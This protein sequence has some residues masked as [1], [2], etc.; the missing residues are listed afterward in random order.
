MK[1]TEWLSE[2]VDMLTSETVNPLEHA[3]LLAGLATVSPAKEAQFRKLPLFSDLNPSTP[4]QRRIL[5]KRKRMKIKAKDLSIAYQSHLSGINN[6]QARQ[7]SYYTPEEMADDLAMETL[8]VPVDKALKQPDPR[9][10]LLELTICDPACGSGHFLLAAMRFI[11]EKA[12]CHGIA[13]MKED[14]AKCLFGIDIDPTAVLLCRLQLWIASR[15][16]PGENIVCDDAL[17]RSEEAWSRQDRGLGFDAILSNPPYIDSERMKRETPH[18]RNEIAKEWSSARGNWDLYVP[19]VELGLKRTKSG[20]RAGFLTPIKLFGADY[21]ATIQS[22]LL[23]HRIATAKI[24]ETLEAF[25]NATVAVMTSVIDK[26]SQGPCHFF[27]RIDSKNVKCGEW[28]IEE[29]KRLPKGHWSLPF[30]ESAKSIE[31]LQGIRLGDLAEIRDGATTGEAYRIRER[32]R[33]RKPKNDD[34][35]IINTGL[36]D[37]HR[38]LWGKRPIRYLGF[39]GLRPV[40]SA[41]DLHE[42][43]PKRLLQANR[44]KTLVGGMGKRIEAVAVPSKTLCGKSAVQIIPQKGI[45]AFA[46]AAWLNSDWVCRFYAALF[47]LRGMGR[48]ALN[49]GPRQIRVLPVIQ[50]EITTGSMLSK[51]GRILAENP[52][53]KAILDAVDSHCRALYESPRTD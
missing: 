28:T 53:D 29:M 41:E 51:W 36:I 34:I 18:L 47:Q 5:E 30:F 20:G 12:H 40:I 46:L 45:C 32:I 44:V 9:K 3:L 26:D 23:R 10:S 15:Y 2:D 13:L 4:A 8:S 31:A 22:Q 14:V 11:I 42:I 27:K 1:M 17:F 6:T 33:D 50:S 16:D 48:G 52:D 38:S 35:K 24:W 43:S 21:C 37:P 19:F 39:K 49:I 7:G 25:E